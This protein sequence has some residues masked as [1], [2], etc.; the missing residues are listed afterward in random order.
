MDASQTV[1]RDNL[2][3]SLWMIAAMA[4][5]AV[6]DSLLKI[7]T[8]TLPVSQVLVVFGIL[9]AS[10]FAGLARRSGAQLFTKDVA[11]RAMRIRF[12]FEFLGRLFYILAL[13]LTSLSGTTVILQ[14]TP[15]VVVAGAAIF[16]GEKV[17][18]RR[19]SAIAIGLFGVLV[20]L[21]P[22][23]DDFSALSI[24]AIIGM[25]GFAGRDLASRAAPASLRPSV[26]G[27][28]GFVTLVIAG[29]SFA[30]W[31]G[32]AYVMPDT[33][34]ATIV[35]AAVAVGVFSYTSLMKAMRTG[36]VSIVTPFR[37]IR[38]IFGVGLGVVLFG[39]PLDAPTLWGSAI[40]VG[41]GLFLLSR[42]NRAKS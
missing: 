8:Q 19:W 39:E 15:L 17:G 35:V 1:A 31:E 32:R 9:G 20:V 10:V 23:S 11:S 2:T 24:L 42:G 16:L 41:A 4:G 40:I 33:K 14:A 28:Y 37:Y 38:L 3:G 13:T 26:L 6:E 30:I 36:Q 34:T 21:R 18:W 22:S 12:V 27:F 29:A 25:L 7:A 5:F